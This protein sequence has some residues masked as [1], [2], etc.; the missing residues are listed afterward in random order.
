MYVSKNRCKMLSLSSSLNRMIYEEVRNDI[1]EKVSPLVN[2]TVMELLLLLDNPDGRV[3]VVKEV[4]REVSREVR[5][6]MKMD[7]KVVL[8]W[9]GDVMVGCCKGLRQNNG[10][11]TQCSR[12]CESEYCEN[13]VKLIEK[14]GGECPYG[15]VNDRMSCGLLEYVDPK[16]KKVVAY[17]NVMRKLNISREEA[18]KE[19]LRLN[20]TIPEC[21][22]EESKGKRGRPKKEKDVNEVEKEKKKRGRP[23][24]VKEKVSNSVGEELI[25]SLLDQTLIEDEVVN[26]VI[27]DEELAEEIVDESDE[28]GE[29]TDVVKFEHNGKEYLKS[30]NNILF[31]IES[32]DAL[33]IWN[34]KEGKI[35]A[36]PDEDDE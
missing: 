14:N 10:L 17:S 32:H 9:C 35:D 29:E 26:D 16:G 19:A 18:E 20:I 33:G 22:F 36:I 30:E 8:P 21:H 6:E 24:K 1:L 23:K 4:S 7:I 15:N 28:E 34:E 27:V 12:M 3:D 2:I 13:C 5:K 11:Y 31:D 25:A